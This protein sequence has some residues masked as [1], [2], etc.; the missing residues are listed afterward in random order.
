MSKIEDKRELMFHHYREYIELNYEIFDDFC[1]TITPGFVH[2]PGAYRFQDW[3]WDDYDN[4]FEL[5][6][7]D[8]DLR[9]TEQQFRVIHEDMGFH[10]GWLNHLD[11]WETYYGLNDAGKFVESRRKK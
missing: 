6:E 4:S 10:H 1:E 2:G 3:R 5:D 7:C 8:N 11:Y 9:L